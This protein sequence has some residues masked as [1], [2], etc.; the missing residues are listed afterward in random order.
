MCACCCVLLCDSK[1]VDSFPV[2]FSIKNEDR[3]RLY[4]LRDHVVIIIIII[5]I[6]VIIFIIIIHGLLKIQTCCHR[7]NCFK[8]YTVFNQMLC[9][10]SDVKL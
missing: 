5:I 8:L 6:I 2:F 3:L 10:R 1:L 7:Q 4:H 9:R